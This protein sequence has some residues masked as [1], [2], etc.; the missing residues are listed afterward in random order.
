MSWVGF[1]HCYCSG[2]GVLVESKWGG[3]GGESLGRDWNGQLVEVVVLG[4]GWG[5]EKV[6][7]GSGL[8]LLGATSCLQ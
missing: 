2:A 3:R 4:W 1:L 8:V 6:G 5:L 7:L